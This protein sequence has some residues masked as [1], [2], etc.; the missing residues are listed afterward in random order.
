MRSRFSAFAVRDEAYLLRS[1]HPSTRP[2]RVEFDPAV[3]WTGL[4]VLGT[5]AGSPSHTEGTV[6]FRARYTA[7]GRAGELRENSSF[8]RHEGAWVYLDGAV[9]G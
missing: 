3:R 6:E 2:P 1:W 5:T 8:V 4:E 9:D 7:R